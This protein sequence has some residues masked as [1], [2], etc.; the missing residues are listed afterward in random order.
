MS[1]QGAKKLKLV[2]KNYDYMQ[3]ARLIDRQTLGELESQII[4]TSWYTQ[5]VKRDVTGN[6]KEVLLDIYRKD[7]DNVDLLKEIRKTI[8][9]IFSSKKT[10]QNKFSDDYPKQFGNMKEIPEA[11]KAFIKELIDQKFIEDYFS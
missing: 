10:D 1:E 8:I 11:Q 7:P 4:F 9:K 3:F 6:L 5:K 2:H